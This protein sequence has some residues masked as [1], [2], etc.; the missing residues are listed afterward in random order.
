MIERHKVKQIGN[1]IKEQ[2]KNQGKVWKKSIPR[3]KNMNR[4]IVIGG[5][6]PYAN[7][8]LHIGHL[9]GLLPGDVLARYFR[10]AGDD[11]YYVSGSD[12]HGTPVSMRAKAEN[13]SPEEISEHYHQEFCECFEKL[14]FSYDVYGKTSQ[15]EHKDFIQ[16]FHRRLYQSPYVYEKESP[17]AYCKECGQFLADRFVEGLCPRCGEESRGDQCEVCGMVLEPEALKKPKCAL[18][19]TTPVFRYTKHLHIAISK[20]Q[21]ELRELVDQHPNWRKNAIAFTNRYLEEGVRDRTLTRDLSWGIDVPKEGYEKKKIYIWAENVLGYLSMSALAARERGVA[22]EE[23]WKGDNTRHYYVHA[24]DNIP[25][26]T[27]ILPA[28]LLAEGSGYHLPDDIISNEYLTLEGRKISTSQNWA[29]WVKDM[30]D[31]YHPDAI[32]YFFIA[33]GP[34]K[35]DTDFSFREFVKSNNGELLGAYGNFVNRSLVFIYKYLDAR[36]PEGRLEEDTKKR[37][38]ELYDITGK[39][40]EGGHLKDALERVFESVR[41]GNKY[42]DTETPWV[43]RE[44]DKARCDN[45][46]FNCVQ[47]IA[48]FAVL[49]SP[50]LP[51]SSRQIREWLGIEESWGFQQVSSGYPIPKPEVLFERLEVMK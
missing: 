35:R 34:E 1:Q 50:F 30:V 48:N 13:R 40:I 15:Q 24:K 51:F 45:T 46:L 23:L 42:F 32:R 17:L 16:E 44:S 26:H 12:C 49:L 5:A 27:I 14:G 4:K 31:C 10:A 37:I 3:E 43:T 20:L 19:G 22:F 36:V 11:V 25:F 47:L 18:C 33:N 21:A 7:G 28:L 38:E 6:W 41:A 8:L 2:I 9:A 39:Q 29:V